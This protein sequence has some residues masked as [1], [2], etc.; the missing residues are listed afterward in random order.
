MERAVNTGLAL[1][2]GPKRWR[3]NH[4]L[5]RAQLRKL[6]RKL[7]NWKA[8]N[9]AAASL[10]RERAIADPT[11]IELE[12]VARHIWEGGHQEEA[13]KLGIDGLN[14]LHSAGL[15]GHATSFAKRLLKWN[16]QCLLLSP[17]DRGELM[18][19]ASIAA[20]HAGQPIE[21]QDACTRSR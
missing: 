11:G 20:E 14:R 3:F 17:T 21:A 6:C 10:R 2:Q 16:D 1:E 9:L 5:I 19:L 12:V 4:D 7:P 8:L 15:M 18:L 13:L